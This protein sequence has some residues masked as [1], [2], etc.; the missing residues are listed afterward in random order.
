[1]GVCRDRS[2]TAVEV[3]RD[4][5]R[6]LERDALRGDGD[7]AAAEVVS[8]QTIPHDHRR[9]AAKSKLNLSTRVSVSP[10]LSSACVTF[11]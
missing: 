10:R 11:A 8:K 3:Q 2:G 9:E 5:S 6:P 7:A 4:G 1:M